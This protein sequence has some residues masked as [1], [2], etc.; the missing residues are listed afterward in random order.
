M[1]S[2]TR[3]IAC[4]RSVALAAPLM[5][6]AQACQTDQAPGQTPA[7]APA[8]F[9]SHTVDDATVDRWMKELS[10]W[11]RWGPD[12]RLGGLNL[13]T[14]TTRRAAFALVRE[15]VSVSLSRTYA[16]DP[17]AGANAPFAHQMFG[18]GGS[19]PFVSDRYAFTYH[20]AEQSH[21]DAL[22]HMAYRGMMY[23]NVPRA[24]VTDAGCAKLSIMDVKEGIAVRAVLMDIPRLKGVDYLPPGAPIYAEDLAAWEKQTGVK[25]RSGDLLLIRTGRWS[26][27]NGQAFQTEPGA[28]LHVSAMPWIKAHDIALIGSDYCTDLV[29]SGLKDNALPDHM[30]LLVAM[31]VR[32]FDNLDLEALAAEAAKRQRWE[33]LVTAAPLTVE[34]GTGSPINPIAHF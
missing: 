27:P 2:M 6:M 14:P 24:A 16:K 23:N 20:G 33:F 3:L 30:L 5:V 8:A 28:G 29:P 32:I 31:G 10:N 34:G 21:F 26:L 11:G 19:G 18:V 13:I 9:A 25:V 12:D 22:C 7:A 1:Q 17:K 15:G 4:V